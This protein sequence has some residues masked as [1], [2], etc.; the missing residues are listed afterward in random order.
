MHV[1]ELLPLLIQDIAFHLIVD[2][3]LISRSLG[4]ILPCPPRR[5]AWS[6]SSSQPGIV[7]LAHLEAM[8]RRVLLSVLSSAQ[9]RLPRGP[10]N[11]VVLH[12]HRGQ[13]YVVAVQARI[14]QHLGIRQL[15]VHAWLLPS[16]NVLDGTRNYLVLQLLRLLDSLLCESGLLM[17]KWRLTSLE[18]RC[19]VDVSRD[20]ASIE[21]TVHTVLDIV[22]GNWWRIGEWIVSEVLRQ[23]ALWLE[24]FVRPHGADSQFLQLN[25][26]DA[27]LRAAVLESIGLG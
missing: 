6:S 15:V 19:Q 5:L 20:D 27:T 8:H 24:D 17:R 14:R 22:L 21:E 12:V 1:F 4:S 26:A 3:N 9:I 10:Q 23:D 2:R 13:E 11:V 18:S 16:P 7:G 25:I